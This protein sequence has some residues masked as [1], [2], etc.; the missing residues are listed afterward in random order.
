M[1][2]LITGS[3]IASGKASISRHLK[4]NSKDD[5]KDVNE[6]KGI[7]KQVKKYA[8]KNTTGVSCFMNS[9]LQLLFCSEV[10]VKV[11]NEANPDRRSRV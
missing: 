1:K 3:A 11:I 9:C 2:L 7:G 6:F 5:A 4:L 8:L 10:A